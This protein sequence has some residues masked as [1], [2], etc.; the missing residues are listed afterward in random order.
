MDAKL[1]DAL[2]IRNK[3]PN[4]HYIDNVNYEAPYRTVRTTPNEGE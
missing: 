4:M 1:V 2:G 3:F